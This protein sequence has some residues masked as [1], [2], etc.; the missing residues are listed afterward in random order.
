MFFLWRGVS[1]GGNVLVFLGFVGRRVSGR[2]SFCRLFFVVV[3][4]SL[5]WSVGRRGVK[6]E[7]LRN[8]EEVG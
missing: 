2:G 5:R 6:F 1:F 3:G 4:R 8:I 7:Y